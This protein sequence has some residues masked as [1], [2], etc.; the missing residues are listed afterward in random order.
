[1]A[2]VIHI[3]KVRREDRSPLLRIVR[4]TGVFNDEEVAIA[5]ELIDVATTVP[6]QTDYTV[7]VYDHEGVSGYYCLGPTPATAGTF[8]LYW[9]A[10]DPKRHRGGIGKALMDHAEEVVASKHGRL[11]VVETSSRKEY[12]PT[13]LFYSGAG[14]KE[15]AR[16]GGYYRPDDDLV[17]FGKYLP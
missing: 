5:L 9:I 7:F 1:M 13:R 14:Y 12:E 8:D 4:E 2:D 11:I 6:D 10:V 3:R 17:V 15:L 16:I